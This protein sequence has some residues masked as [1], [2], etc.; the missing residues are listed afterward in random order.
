MRKRFLDRFR[1]KNPPDER[2]TPTQIMNGV[3]R[4]TPAHLELHQ[5]RITPIRYRRALH[6]KTVTIG[7]ETKEI[8]Y[9]AFRDSGLTEITIPDGVTNLGREAFRDCKS[10]IHVR[11]GRGITVIPSGCF[12]N[13]SALRSVHLPDT[14]TDIG[15]L[16]FAGC[17]QLESLILPESVRRIAPGAFAGCVSLREI[18]LPEGITELGRSVFENCGSLRRIVLPTSVAQISRYAFSGCTALEQ[19]DFTQ[20]D[21]FENVWWDTPFWKQRHPDRIPPIRLPLEMTGTHDG[22]WLRGK[23]YSFFKPG[24]EYVISVPNEHGVVEVTS[25]CGEDGPDEDGFGREEYY[26]W[27]LLDEKLQPIPGVRMY[28]SYSRLDMRG[29][30]A[31]WTALKQKAADILQCRR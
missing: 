10:L 15:F 12:N 18:V 31:E 3:I 14:V 29:I 1:R 7:P 20:A 11:L 24:R 17:G 25:W 8:G 5:E 13:C 30:E 19:V 22:Q 4:E 23:G 9:D 27:W 26:D 21:R 16:A 28:H 2:L 6:L